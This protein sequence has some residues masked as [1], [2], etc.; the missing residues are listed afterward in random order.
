[1]MMTLAL[2]L[3]GEK[4]T[5]WTQA[6][7]QLAMDSVTSVATL[8]I[9][10][11]ADG[12][13]ATQDIRLSDRVRLSIYGTT[14]LS[15]TITELRASYSDDGRRLQLIVKDK[16]AALAKNCPL[17]RQWRNASPVQIIRD[18]AAEVGATV[19]DRLDAPLAPLPS[20]AIDPG[21][22]ALAAI[23]RIVKARGV[24]VLTDN[25][26]GIIID[27]KPGE[28]LAAVKLVEAENLFSIEASDVTEE[29]FSEIVVMGQSA[30]TDPKGRTRNAA[31][32]V[33]TDAKTDPDRTRLVVTADGQATA[34][35][36]QRQAQ[37]QMATNNAKALKVN[38]VVKEWR[39]RAGGPLWQLGDHVTVESDSAGVNESLVIYELNFTLDNAGGEVTA[40]QL[41]RAD[42]LTPN[43]VE[44]QDALT[45][46]GK[47]KKGKGK[48][49]KKG[50]KVPPGPIQEIRNGKWVTVK[51]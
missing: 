27:D 14:L 40:M 5:D 30:G 45:I 32:G 49:K 34:A 9:F 42:A 11:A 4:M 31:R 3:N 44:A 18:L 36:C 6:S 17:P 19:T 24:I 26:G 16:T 29:R 46:K 20:F 1:M 15:G 25:A 10:R 39:Q 12:N 8:S 48:K 28:T 51:P 21:E 35:D 38:A 50:G 37:W 47:K 43:P 41:L 2:H 7:V 33:A 13:L 23:Q 22:T